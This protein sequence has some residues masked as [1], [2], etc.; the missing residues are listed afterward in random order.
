M[1]CIQSLVALNASINNSA[2]AVK[3]VNSSPSPFS[4]PD[5][6]Q[7]LK[8]VLQQKAEGRKHTETLPATP[9]LGFAAERLT[10]KEY[11][12]QQHNIIAGGAR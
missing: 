5:R 8:Q 3:I 10:A 2:S 11:T 1:F 9:L 4:L 7:T 6:L 12:Q